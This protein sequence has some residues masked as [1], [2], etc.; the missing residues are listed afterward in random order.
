[1]SVRLTGS[2]HK[3]LALTFTDPCR[4]VPVSAARNSGFAA[5]CK[6][7]RQSRTLRSGPQRRSLICQA[8]AAGDLSA[9]KEKFGALS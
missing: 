1:M 8:A 7:L 4:A 5:P 3:G 9:L 2:T 6:Q